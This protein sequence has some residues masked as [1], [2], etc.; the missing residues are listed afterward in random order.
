ML[1]SLTSSS[2]GWGDTGITGA[3]TDILQETLA[4]IVDMSN[5]PN[6]G[7]ETQG[8]I[9]CAGGAVG[10]PCKVLKNIPFWKCLS[11]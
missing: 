5:C 11:V 6:S 4:P 7:V 3:S 9:L 10:R 8:L 2:P 1:I